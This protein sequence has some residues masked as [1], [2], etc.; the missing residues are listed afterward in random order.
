M[1]AGTPNQGDKRKKEAKE[2]GT[3]INVPKHQ[4]KIKLVQYQNDFEVKK[5]SARTNDI[6]LYDILI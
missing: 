3:R 6:W 5:S 2:T 4:T 1:T